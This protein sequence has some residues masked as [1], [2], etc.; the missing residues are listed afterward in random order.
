MPNGGKRVKNRKMISSK[1]KKKKQTDALEEKKNTRRPIPRPNETEEEAIIR[2]F[3]DAQRMARFRARRKKAL[4]ESRV[5]REEQL[6]KLGL[7]SELKKRNILFQVLSTVNHPISDDNFSQNEPDK[8][9]IVPLIGDSKYSQLLSVIQEIGKDIKLTYAG[10]RNSIEKLKTEIV[11]AKLLVK[12]CLLET[13][14]NSRHY[15][16]GY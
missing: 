15:S 6:T 8:V 5:L 10:S 7:I 3:H 4:E 14:L 13:E 11:Q 1:L 2:R 12:D 9:T 16:S